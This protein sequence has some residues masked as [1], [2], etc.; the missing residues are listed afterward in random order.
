M[1]KAASAPTAQVHIGFKAVQPTLHGR[2]AL[3]D[4]PAILIRVLF[5]TQRALL[6]TSHHAPRRLQ[7]I[8]FAIHA[9]VL[10]MA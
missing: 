1:A 6:E 7:T 9:Y 3:D 2:P 8:D 5:L 4:Q 10:G